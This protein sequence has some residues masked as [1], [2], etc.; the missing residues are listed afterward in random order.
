MPE[1]ITGVNPVRQD[2]LASDAY[3]QIGDHTSHLWLDTNVEVGPHEEDLVA[4]VRESERTRNLGL[5]L[6]PKCKS[7]LHPFLAVKLHL[8]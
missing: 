4:A 1:R 5:F 3:P 7:N 2:I 6:V 8:S